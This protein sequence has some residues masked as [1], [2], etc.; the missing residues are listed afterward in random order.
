MDNIVDQLFE[1]VKGETGP[2]GYP[3]DKGLSGFP[4]EKGTSFLA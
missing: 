1:Y 2:K 3:G 4:G